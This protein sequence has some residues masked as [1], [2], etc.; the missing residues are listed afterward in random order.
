MSLH[1]SGFLLRTGA[2]STF[3][4]GSGSAAVGAPRTANVRE[5]RRAALGEVVAQLGRVPSGREMETSLK[6][7]GFDVSHVTITQKD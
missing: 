5:R 3:Q 7:R 6:A 1:Y 2:A 4:P